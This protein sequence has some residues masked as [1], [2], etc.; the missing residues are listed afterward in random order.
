[1]GKNGKEKINPMRHLYLP[2]I[3]V[4]LVLFMVLSILI[5]I[6]MDGQLKKAGN[7]SAEKF[8][9]LS[10][11]ALNEMKIASDNLQENRIFVSYMLSDRLTSEDNEEITNM[12]YRQVS[13]LPYVSEIIVI[14][15]EQENVYTSKARYKYDSFRVI[16]SQ[17]GIATA[18]DDPK[19][20]EDYGLKPGWAVTDGTY[21]V[22]FYVSEVTD[23]ENHEKSTIIVTLNKILYLRTL[24]ANTADFCCIYNDDFLLS[25]EVTF[26]PDVDYKSE[27]GISR[28]IGE[29]VAI[30]TVEDE[31]YTYLV[32]LSKNSFFRPLYIIFFAMGI[33]F[34]V[35]LSFA[36]IHT[37]KVRKREKEYLNGLIEGLP[38]PS[39]K[40]EDK[41]V[42][43]S[44]EAAFEN[45]K[46]EHLDYSRQL[47]F[48]NLRSLINGNFNPQLEKGFLNSLG[49]ETNAKKYFVLDLHVTDTGIVNPDMSS[50]FVCIII[51]A[52]IDSMLE[53]RAAATVFTN[54]ASY[55]AIITSLDE[56]M[57]TDKILS[58]VKKASEITM[59]DY[60]CQ[61][62]CSI[63]EP[64]DSL[65]SI[66]QAF[67]QARTTS[68]FIH[69]IDSPLQI[70]TVEQLKNQPESLLRGKFLKQTQT[71][72]NTLLMRKY[73]LAE[74]MVD[75]ILNDNIASIG[76][77]YEMASARMET[78]A[79]IL[80][81]T[82]APRKM[83]MSI[84]NEVKRKISN[85][86]TVAGFSEA[87][88]EYLSL[89]NSYLENDSVVSKA[90]EFIESQ[91]SNISLGVPDVAEASNVSVQYLSR[92]FRQDV[93]MT[94]V[95]YIN[96]HR[97]DKAKELLA[98]TD[99]TVTEIAESTGYCNNVT[100]S[101]NF[102]KYVDCT[103]SE[104]R[105]K[106]G[107][108]G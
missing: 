68:E 101:R 6:I 31:N 16:F 3:V 19:E 22:P 52:A 108:K 87:S 7:L 38:H 46:Q 54:E 57:T 35:V 66:P 93:N 105:Q 89:L 18:S 14:S 72:L 41:P 30:F 5:F 91:I 20:L 44:I 75:T 45:Y 86:N 64:V 4:P 84:L 65:N 58:A 10:Q 29:P 70:T 37:A 33:Y 42:L 103:P 99:K 81:E 83:D 59:D 94:V 95:E 107:G 90:C 26:K 34:L 49:I 88:H 85:E 1:M 55:G 80:R 47:R 61:F 40:T 106:A 76:K 24:V 100:F 17:Q 62:R 2:L 12:L 92:L 51:N 25:S 73:D 60:G 79:T 67:R 98:N 50:D 63:S 104:Y 102:K 32:G 15:P 13:N 82:P 78:I 28:I 74:A 23:G 27:E 21:G 77:N 36:L 43:A 71:L 11:S 69:A 9:A 53:G 96:K 8:Y 97:I 56:D 39:E 48:K